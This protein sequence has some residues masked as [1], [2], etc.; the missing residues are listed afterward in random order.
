MS[1]VCRGAPGSRSTSVRRCCCRRALRSRRS[2]TCDVGSTIGHETCV[3]SR[4]SSS[5]P[6]SC[7]GETCTLSWSDPGGRQPQGSLQILC[8]LAS[9]LTRAGEHSHTRWQWMPAGNESIS[10]LVFDLTRIKRHYTGT[11]VPDTSGTKSICCP[12]RQSMP[13]ANSGW[14]NGGLGVELRHPGLESID[15]LGRSS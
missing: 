2:S 5:E 15:P 9:P 4:S 14:S 3:S 8:N 10:S 13:E 7:R 6:L 11:P 1:R 12:C